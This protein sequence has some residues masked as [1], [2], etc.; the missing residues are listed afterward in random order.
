VGI[1]YNYVSNRTELVPFVPKTT[2]EG[3]KDLLPVIA[4]A[5]PTTLGSEVCVYGAASGY[6]CGNLIAV[7]A[8]LTVPDIYIH[9]DT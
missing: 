1:D 3:T 6:Q 7:N 4:S 9:S 8:K 2:E 5:N